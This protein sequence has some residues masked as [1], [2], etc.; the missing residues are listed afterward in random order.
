LPNGWFAG[1]SDFDWSF[2][3]RNGGAAT[4]P[5]GVQT[6]KVFKLGKVPVSL[7][8]EGAWLPVRPDG[9]PEWL[10]GVELTVIFKTYR[11]PR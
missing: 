9:S 6:G 2:D 5:L 1:Y 4:I 7:S 8:L 11:H 3:W 10:I